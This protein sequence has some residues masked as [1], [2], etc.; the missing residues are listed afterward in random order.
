MAGGS[1]GSSGGDDRYAYR[2]SVE[3]AADGDEGLFEGLDHCDAEAAAEILCRRNDA[4]LCLYLAE[5]K[6]VWERQ[7]G[8]VRCRAAGRGLGGGGRF[9]NEAGGGGWEAG[10]QP[11]R[12]IG[13]GGGGAAF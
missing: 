2:N 12:W 13:G 11:G 5:R 10:L 4:L 3:V 6:R 7:A 8:A 9:Q 1:G